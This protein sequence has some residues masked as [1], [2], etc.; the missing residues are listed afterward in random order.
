MTPCDGLVVA[1][2]KYRFKEE[3]R[4]RRHLQGGLQMGFVAQEVEEVL[5]ELVHTDSQGFKY[6]AYGKVVPLLVEAVKEL[7]SKVEALERRVGSDD[8]LHSDGN[9]EQ[10]RT[11]PSVSGGHMAMEQRLR[12]LEQENEQLRRELQSA[13]SRLRAIETRLGL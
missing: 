4:L 5:P 6:V 8:V 13:E 2:V 12:E 11:G 1:Q 7:G 9:V 3:P 10:S